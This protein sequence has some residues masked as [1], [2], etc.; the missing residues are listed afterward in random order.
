MK[1][2]KIWSYGD[3][4][5]GDLIIGS[6]RGMMVL[7]VVREDMF[8]LVSW[9]RLWGYDGALFERGDIS[10]TRVYATRC[11]LPAEWTRNP[12]GV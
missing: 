1:R 7:S 3:L 10:R 8:T 6:N 5:P 11:N 9:L 12:G 2:P 4:T